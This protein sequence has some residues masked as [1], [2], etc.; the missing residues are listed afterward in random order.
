[1]FTLE[2][3]LCLPA[4]FLGPGRDQQLWS[5]QIHL[6][7]YAQGFR[8]ERDFP[9]NV[10]FQRNSTFLSLSL[11]SCQCSAVWR[12][13]DLTILTSAI[14][15]PPS[16]SH[17]LGGEKEGTGSLRSERPV[18]K[19]QRRDLLAVCFRVSTG[20]SFL[21]GKMKMMSFFLWTVI[22]VRNNLHKMPSVASGTEYGFL[23]YCTVFVIKRFFWP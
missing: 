20:L 13:P 8:A 7:R 3:A 10:K 16:A 12:L 5:L 1:M 18:F 15:R 9:P 22:R 17:P 23:V 21:M 14:C 2:P 11:L 4:D 6:S 19:S